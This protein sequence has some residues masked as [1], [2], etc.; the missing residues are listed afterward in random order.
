MELTRNAPVASKPKVPRYRPGIYT[1]GIVPLSTAAKFL[2][3]NSRICPGDSKR[4]PGR[5]GGTIDHVI[6]YGP[7]FHLL[8]PLPSETWSVEEKSVEVTMTDNKGIIL[9]RTI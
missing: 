4:N 2:Q 8:E 5:R 7:L 3:N 6:E 1:H 9:F